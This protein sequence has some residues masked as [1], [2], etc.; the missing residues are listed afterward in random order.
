MILVGS[1][2]DLKL[3]RK[4]SYEAGM[5]LAQKYN[6]KLMEVSAKENRNVDD[7]FE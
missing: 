2:S 7:I 6:V 1:K 4:V 5:E 3:D